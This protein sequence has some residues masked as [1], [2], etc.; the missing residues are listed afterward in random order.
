MYGTRGMWGYVPFGFGVI[1]FC[2]HVHT[3]ALFTLGNCERRGRKIQKESR[4]QGKSERRI[5]KFEV[6]EC[7]ES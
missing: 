1:Y 5:E 3:Y 6:L 4:K 2:I 7:V